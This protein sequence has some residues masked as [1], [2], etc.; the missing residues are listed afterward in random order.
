MR[1]LIIGAGLSGC[2]AA[3]LLKDKKHDIFI[4]EKKEIVGGLCITKIGFD[5]LKYEPYG[6]KIFHS[7]NPEVIK[8]I[9]KFDDFNG[10]NHRKGIIIN[11]KLFQFPINRESINKFEKRDLILDELKNLPKEI[12]KS[13]FEKACISIFGNTLYNCFI[14]NYTLKMW[15]VEPKN[16]TA[17]WAISRLEFRNDSEDKLFK[18]QWQGVPKKG[19][20]NLLE[21]M[22]KDIPLSLSTSKYNSNGYD[23]IVSSSPID[24]ILDYKFG[25]LQYRSIRFDY[26]IGGLWE[27]DR[28]GTINLPQHSKYIRKCNFNIIHKQKSSKYLI[29]FQEPIAADENNMPMYPI[30]TEENNEIFDKYLKEICKTNICP[31]GRLGLFKYLDMDKTIEIV[32]KMLPIIENYL[33]LNSKERYHRIKE[34][35]DQ[36]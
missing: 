8:F 30:N 4:I 34:I 15:G 12:D 21:K 19:Y 32:F 22:I 6:S 7:K 1:I 18:D 35:R 16:L 36:Y 28:Y 2:T 26:K 29:Q 24:E 23:I 13:N 27:N 20:S 9:S 11:G 3:R 25:R 14:K 33:E 5:N 10:Y 31:I 17:E